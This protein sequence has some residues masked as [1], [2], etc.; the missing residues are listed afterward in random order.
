[1]KITP[2]IR[3]LLWPL[4][5]HHS[6]YVFSYVAQRNMVVKR[7]DGTT[8]RLVAGQRY[9][10]T[11]DGLRRIWNNIREEPICRRP[12]TTDSGCT[13]C[14]TISRSTF[15]AITRAPTA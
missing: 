3:A 14:G 2:T 13:I 5:G 9:P 1:M 4:R 6:R 10:F 8:E 15:C 11:K 7:K 12:A